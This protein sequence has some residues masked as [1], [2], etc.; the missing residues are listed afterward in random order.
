MLDAFCPGFAV[1]REERILPV[2]RDRRKLKEVACDN[3][4]YSVRGCGI[5]PGVEQH[6]CIPPKGRSVFFRSS[7][8]SLARVSKR[9]PSTIETTIEIRTSHNNYVKGAHLRR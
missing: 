5:S 9:Y 7:T 4:L 8:A 3:K 1:E 6:T 2:F